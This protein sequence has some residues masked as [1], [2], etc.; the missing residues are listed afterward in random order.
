MPGDL[1]SRNQTPYSEMTSKAPRDQQ[2]DN[3]EPQLLKEQES[4]RRDNL[5][6][7]DAGRPHEGGA[8]ATASESMTQH[9]ARLLVCEYPNNNDPQSAAPEQNAPLERHEMETM[10]GGQAEHEQYGEME[11]RAP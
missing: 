5:S 11:M 10:G 4:K 2:G 9:T 6:R 7:Q 1:S 3:K 8:V